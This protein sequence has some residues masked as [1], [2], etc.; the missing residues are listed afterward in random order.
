MLV[1]VL[2][3]FEAHIGNGPVDLGGPR[4]RA[5][6]AL[7]LTARGEVVSVDR[8]IEDLWHGEAPPRAI[9]SLQAY[10]SNLRRLLEP[11]REPRTPARL[12]VSAPPG[13]AIRLAGDAVDAWRFEA[14]LG[15]ARAASRAEPEQARRLLEQA[16]GLWRGGAYAEF[17]AE[18]W[19]TA[20]AGRLDQL[21]LVARELLVDVSLHSGP[22][23]EVV[24]QAELLAHQ[25]PLREERWRLLA[26]ALWASGRQADALAALRRAR[27]VL[28]DE[29]GLDPGPG[30]VE[31]EQAILAQ[32]VDLLPAVA[33]PPV[34]VERVPTAQ[35]PELFVGRAAELGMLRQAAADAP[36]VVLVTGEAGV[37]KSSL[38]ALFQRELTAGDWLVA[39]GRCPEESGAPA[40]W[41]WVEALRSLPP[42]PDHLAGALRPLLDD[43]P[44]GDSPPVG[45]FRLHRAVGDWLR[46]VAATR[47]LAVFVDDLHWADAETLAL[48]ASV[49]EQTATARLLLVTAF[50][51]EEGREQ[52][53]STLAALARRSPL[54]LPLDGLPADDVAR[55][56][57]A[58]SPAPVDAETLA[59]LAER[60]GGNPFYIRESARLLA[61]EGA[62]VGLSE[63]PEGVRDVLRRRLAR[64]PEQ[65][66]AVLR[67]AAVTGRGADVET[68]VD[69]A[70]AVGATET[71]VFDALE[72]GLIAGL[73]TEPAPGRV[74]F[75]HE[76]VRDTVY[77]DL[78]QLRRMRL[79]ARV[80]E[81]IRRLRP[82]D[83]PALAHHYVRA[84]S[85][86]SATLA[87]D[88]SVRAAELAERRYAHD[89]AVD[90]LEGA[91]TAAERVPADDADAERVAL[92]GRLIRAQIRA[93]AVMAARA[94]RDRALDVALAAGREDLVVAAFAS[95]T[96]PTPWQ[97]HPYGHVDRRAVDLLVRLLGRTDLDP[98]TRCRLLDALTC[99][100]DGESDPRAA[101]AADE[102]VALARQLDDPALLA[103]ALGAAAR[104]CDF[105]REVARRVELA[106]ELRALATRDDLIPYRWLVE[107]ILSNAAGATGDV[108]GLRHRLETGLAIA[109]KYQL[110]EPHAVMLCGQ[111]MLAHVAGRFDEAERL[112]VEATAEMRRH[113]SLHAVAFRVLAL[114]TIRTSQ[115]RLGEFA[116][117]AEALA[118]EYGGLAADLFAV[119]L[120]AAG[121]RDEA[122]ARRGPLGPL[123]DDYFFTAF[124]T[125]RAMAIVALDEREHA[126][127]LIE[128]LLPRRDQL[129][130]AASCAL[131]LQPVAH[132]LGELYL[133]L[134]RPAEAAEHFAHAV[135]IAE[136]WGSPH[137]SAAAARALQVV[138]KSAGAP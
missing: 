138:H 137:W 119:A 33:E 90:L 77:T 23:A 8:L 58:I 73:L 3:S 48:L 121:R 101:E 7:L 66:V 79:H 110:K 38:Q 39:A 88:Y 6:L 104:V 122:K 1:G 25:E 5:V 49:A 21:R 120:V 27:R 43:E 87:V 100:L 123:L 53:A 117:E 111:A 30:L 19:A 46:T 67:L 78:P 93:G 134:D 89:A 45:R 99:E 72:A 116:V 62:L 114:V 63:V 80:A 41:A 9:A 129:A 133:L 85:S 71:A 124:A 51:T 61:S 96:E 91:L 47:P 98:V 29:L 107:Q 22:A 52:L 81:A 28:A 2:G 75:V 106:E 69:A 82:D 16:L 54:R 74:R 103:M 135:T 76:L 86:E 12:L 94:T 17:A 127:A 118:A 68:L 112:Y 83:L 105:E 4:Q 40:A 13:Y 126:A 31:L 37:G 70:E 59:A 125:L 97:T 42:P 56:V 84:A 109:D 11:D 18:P 50:R 20:E 24:P 92:L 36:G 131:A 10:V 128:Q 132:T 32:R 34:L 115:G 26:L 64:L 65:A 95:W 14:L 136:R 113:G 55:L 35:T 44:T 57:S 108:E 15:E 102:A 60:T 130:G